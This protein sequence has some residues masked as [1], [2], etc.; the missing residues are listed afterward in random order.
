L[1]EQGI[2]IV[3]TLINIA[4][5]PEMAAPGRD[6]FPLYYAHMLDLYERRHATV[7]AAHDAGVPIYL[8]TDAGSSLPHGLVAEEAAELVAAGLS[9]VEALTAG[10]WGAREWL[11]KPGI[12][13]GASA[14]LVVYESDPRADIAVLKAPN[15]IVLRGQTV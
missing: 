10:A 12:E 6:K 5:L 13:E 11:G 4:R 8:G 7:A 3:P 9:P 15:A 1:A 14:D 2:A